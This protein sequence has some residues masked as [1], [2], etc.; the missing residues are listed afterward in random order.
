[1]TRNERAIKFRNILDKKKVNCYELAKECNTSKQT[2]YYILHAKNSPSPETILDLEKALKLK[3][4]E[5]L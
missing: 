1:M 5:L 3:H 4:G 2:M